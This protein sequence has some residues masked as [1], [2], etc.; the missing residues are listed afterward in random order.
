MTPVGGVRGHMEM[1]ETSEDLR[2]HYQSQLGT[3]FGAAFHG[4][5]NDWAWGL[6]R[7]NEFRNLFTR[8][9]DVA[10]LN[11][12]TGG[13]F[14]WD[15]QYIL[16]DDLLLRVCRLTD[17]CK[18]AGKH[19]LTVRR[20]P[21]FCKE[22]DSALCEEVQ[23]RVHTAVQKAEFARDWRNRRISHTDWDKTM[24]QSQPLAPAS[25]QQVASALDAVHA[26]LNTISNGLLNA[27]I[28]NYVVGSPRAR[29]FLCYTRQ[30][31]EAVKFIDTLVDPDGSARFTDIDIASAFLRKLG[32][33]PTMDQVK[34][35]IEL[36]QAAGRFA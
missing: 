2:Q 7:V 23:R 14:T 33:E 21:S 3:E 19:N 6:M 17:P 18:S 1:N 32:R 20:L 36:R 35:I 9:D 25:L 26:V 27:E 24:L 29:A 5:R 8:A 11:A 30:L 12:I 13:G 16:W 34:R 22:K 15:I 10:L 31:V 4:L 28:G